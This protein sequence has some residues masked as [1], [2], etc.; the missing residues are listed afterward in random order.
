M[1]RHYAYISA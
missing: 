1:N